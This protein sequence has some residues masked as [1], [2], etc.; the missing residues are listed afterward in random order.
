MLHR[1]ERVG[2]LAADDGGAALVE[3]QPH[4]AGDVLLALV[5]QRLQHLALGRTPE[6]VVDRARR[7]CGISSSLRCIAPRSSVID[8]MPRWAPS[9]GSCR[10]ASRRRRAIFMPTKRF[11]TRSRRPMPCLRAELVELGQHA[12]RRQ[13]LAVDGD[14]I[15]L[16][17]VDRDVFGLVRRLLGRDGA[18]VATCPR[19]A[20]SPGILERSCPRYE[21]CSRLASIENGASPRL[22]LAIGIWC[23][24]A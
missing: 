17:E 19:R 14:G 22:S 8:S 5:D 23:F 4:R 1:V 18:L 2:R 13:R 10:P 11:S 3:L 6:A 16:L 15:A 24:S 12:G 9:A 20:P 21:V 7:T